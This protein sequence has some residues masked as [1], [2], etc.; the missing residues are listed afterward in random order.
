MSRS[1]LA[2][3]G[4]APDPPLAFPLTSETAPNTLEQGPVLLGKGVDDPRTLVQ[5]PPLAA[6]TETPTEPVHA[7]DRA[8]SQVFRKAIEQL[9]LRE[10]PRSYPPSQADLAEHERSVDRMLDELAQEG[11]L[12]GV[13]RKELMSLLTYELVAL[14]PLELYLDDPSVTRIFVN[15]PDRMFIERDGK[16]VPAARTFSGPDTLDLA[17]TR[18][19]SVGYQVDEHTHR[20]RLTDGTRIDVVLPPATAHG[21]A[22]VVF[23]EPASYRNIDDLVKA[24]SLSKEIKAFLEITIQARRTILIAGPVGTGK[25][26]LLNAIGSLIPDDERIVTVENNAVLKLQ[27]PGVVSLESAN[28]GSARHNIMQ[29]AMRLAPGRILLD[30]IGPHNAYEW[31]VGTAYAAAGSVAT[32]AGNGE[33]DALAKL[34]SLALPGSPLHSIRGLREQI[35]RAVQFVIVLGETGHVAQVVEVQGIELDA[36]RLQDVFYHEAAG[37]GTGGGF[38]ATGHIPVFCEELRRSGTETDLS[39]FRN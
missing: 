2:G 33:R 20:M 34:E 27:Q 23:K 7:F 5:R 29:Y 11:A 26:E 19:L 25:T 9:P 22:I 6:G 8:Q 28:L 10:L 4:P 12:D 30:D 35:A 32:I 36:L 1:T 15:S 17:V 16:T 38:H 37:D 14:G 18:L 13:D 21:P 24:G 3:F 31:I 39:I